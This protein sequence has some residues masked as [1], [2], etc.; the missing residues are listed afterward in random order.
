MKTSS[1]L[2]YTTALKTVL[3]LT[4]CDDTFDEWE[5]FVDDIVCVSSSN[6]FTKHELPFQTRTVCESAS[7]TCCT[8]LQM[9]QDSC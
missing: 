9:S 5:T 6:Y 7:R 1:M 3:A 4:V 8:S 2:L